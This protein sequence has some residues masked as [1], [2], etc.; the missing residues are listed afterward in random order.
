ME[1]PFVP[2]GGKE[3]L[4]VAKS[5]V[6]FAAVARDPPRRQTDG[7]T[8]RQWATPSKTWPEVE[9]KNVDAFFSRVFRDST[10]KLYS[11]RAGR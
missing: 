4:V 11:R 10:G 5:V 6:D 3:K 9:V 8:D 7:Q 2:F 1:N